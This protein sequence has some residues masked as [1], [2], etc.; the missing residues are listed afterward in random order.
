MGLADELIGKAT[1]LLNLKVI[2]EKNFF[3]IPASLKAIRAA[4]GKTIQTILDNLKSQI[5]DFLSGISP[6]AIALLGLGALVNEFSDDNLREAV[7]SNKH[8]RNFK[9]QIGLQIN[10]QIAPEVTVACFNEDYLNEKLQ[11]LETA[12]S[13]KPLDANDYLKV[14]LSQSDFDERTNPSSS[15]NDLEDLF[16]LVNSILPWLL[17]AYDLFLNI[18]DYIL[19]NRYPSTFRTN[20]LQGQVRQFGTLL[21]KSGRSLGV[22][23]QSEVDSL[24]GPFKS[25]DNLITGL[26]IASFLY[27]RNRGIGQESSTSQL[28]EI[29]TTATCEPF[30]PAFDVS[31]NPTDIS[32]NLDGFSC[33]VPDG[34]IVPHTP[35]NQKLEGFS[36]EVVLNEPDASITAEPQSD[37]ASKAII[38]NLSP[39]ENF[40][41]YLRKDQEVK[42][43]TPIGKIGETPIYSSVSGFVLDI[44]ENQVWLRDISDVGN[45]LL[46]EETTRLK[47]LYAELNNSNR[48][49]KDFKILS[50]YLPM[51]ASTPF[52]DPSSNTSATKTKSIRKRWERLRK[53][54]ARTK[55]N[56]NK[57]ARKKTDSDN[58]KTQAENNTL[59]NIR[60]D[61]DALNAGLQ[62]DLDALA[63][64]GINVS[65]VTKVGEEDLVYFDYLQ[66]LIN[67]CINYDDQNDLVISYR[68]RLNEFLLE[69][70]FIEKYN[71]DSIINKIDINCVQLDIA[72]FNFTVPDYYSILTEKYEAN[73]GQ[74][75]I[76]SLKVYLESLAVTNEALTTD[77]KNDLINQTIN[78]FQ[79]TRNILDIQNTEG[80]YIPEDNIATLSY[81]EGNYI[82]NFFGQLSKRVQEIPEE[83]KN[84]EEKIDSLAASYVPPSIIEIED[85]Q[86]ELYGLKSEKT[87]P[88]PE[89]D[90][91]GYLSPN[92]KYTVG[93][94][95][96]WLKYCASATLAS[97][98]NPASGWATGFPPPIG[99]ILLPVVYIP[100]KSFET[101][102]GF[103]VIGISIC[104]IFPSPFVLFGNLATNY[105][106][107]LGDPTAI[108]KNEIQELKKTLTSELKSYRQ[109]V[110]GGY[111]EKQAVRVEVKNEEVETYT[112]EK[113]IHKLQKPVR[114]RSD[115]SPASRQAYL[116]LLAQWTSTQSIYTEKIATSKAER[117]VEETKYKVVYDAFTGVASV[118]SG[119]DQKLTSIANAGKELDK[120]LDKLN[121]L[122]GQINQILIPLPITMKPDTANFAFTAKNPKPIIEIDADVSP[123]VKSNIADNLIEGVNIKNEDFMSSQ[124][125][126]LVSNSLVGNFDKLKSVLNLNKYAMID[127]EAFPKYE[128]L[129]AVNVAWIPFLYKDFVVKGAQSYGIPGQAPFPLPG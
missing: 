51:L 106:T 89:E 11:S 82:R 48:M 71:L 85:E 124:F 66:Y 55:K 38:Q 37:L 8:L 62:K 97:V 6:E 19:S 3:D 64:Q 101:K 35:F 118:E 68:T 76:K 70:F 117:F 25:I 7:R 96:Y 75:P 60:K 121:D 80:D 119:L 50:W 30:V 5:I 103:I 31:I 1:G 53:K 99:P 44:K 95:Q 21:K 115:N 84:V 98:A 29:S 24:I 47:D 52:V 14:A 92:T 23:A 120:Q 13:K 73:N 69:R 4:A 90:L 87:C 54:E 126:D 110:L 108:L 17:L 57:E 122:V 33:P 109:D 129:T 40:V 81:K 91:E 18:K 46:E 39:S 12:L 72:N 79:F 112:E 86:Y 104:G 114:D 42:I 61:V 36:C 16:N 100:F 63:D 59:D 74:E 41:I 49:L 77:E 111:L 43:D 83:I 34:V 27:L 125:Q 20:Y 65:Q 28:E 56:F 107:P 9:K 116:T 88:E 2:K 67:S 45:N 10:E 93:D 105:N 15:N 127:R 32:I 102:W 128:N 94:I 78:L 58:V 26:S 123:V 113:R 22:N